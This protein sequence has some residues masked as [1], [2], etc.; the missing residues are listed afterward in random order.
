[1]LDSGC[2]G[3]P[4]LR[5][6]SAAEVLKAVQ[7][8]DV[9]VHVGPH[10]D[11]VL[12]GPLNDVGARRAK[13]IRRRVVEIAY[14]LSGE[15]APLTA[16]TKERREAI[17][18]CG[19]ILEQ[20][21][22]ASLIVDDIEDDSKVR[23]GEKT[24]H[25]KYG[26]PVALNAGNWLYFW[27]LHELRCLNLP[28]EIELRMYRYCM[29]MYVGAHCGQAFDVGMP[30]DQ[31]KTRDIPDF[32]LASI[33]LK[34]GALMKF[35]MGVPSILSGVTNKRLQLL[36]SFG[37]NFGIAL[38]CFDDIGNAS[39]KVP[40]EKRFEDLKLMRPT[41]IWAVAAEELSQKDLTEFFESVKKYREDPVLLDRTLERMNLRK[42]AYE[43]ADLHLR[44]ALENLTKGFSRMPNFAL[45]LGEIKQLANKLRSTYG[46]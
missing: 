25:R 44:Q 14:G 17:T 1:M 35:A 23:R 3:F 42:I 45:P 39:T 24:L 10:L 28:A 8:S 43:R 34:T 33:R 7:F 20:I 4:P 22:M 32:C 16:D 40:P 27:Q 11:K 13:N 41:W 29:D 37:E 6:P 36:E 46:C 26:M 9:D 21:H 2:S 30:I 19:K 5:M 31:V 18:A 38:Q 12:L 15:K